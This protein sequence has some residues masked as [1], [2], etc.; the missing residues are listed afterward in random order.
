MVSV[1]QCRRMIR[2]KPSALFRSF[3]REVVPQS[4]KTAWL[5]RW[6]W[7]W[8][9]F[10]SAIV[11]GGLFDVAANIFQSV[12]GTGSLLLTPQIIQTI[13]GW[14]RTFSSNPAANT[15]AAINIAVTVIVALGLFII[16]C[17][18]QGV[19]VYGHGGR[20]VGKDSL[21]KVAVRAG[22]KHLGQVMVLT[23]ITGFFA[24][25]V[26]FA[27]LVPFVLSQRTPS[28]ILTLVSI[29]GAIVYL[30]L[31][32]LLI[33]THI[34]ALN[35]IVHQGARIAE[36]FL[37]AW[38]MARREW[39]H[40]VELGFVLWLINSLAISAAVLAFAV[41]GVPVFLIMVAAALL[42]NPA[43][44]YA[45]YFFGGLLFIATMFVTAAITVS[46]Q[47]GVWHHLYLR[48]GEGGLSPKIHRLVRWFM[49][50]A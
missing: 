3:Y 20:A 48:L 8:A 5:E 41:M 2:K 1:I 49:G 35:A 19:L 6:M 42:N 18:A 24:W 33:A 43:V 39:L 28:V 9:I 13:S 47:Y 46:F 7:P 21:A 30:A 17:I 50:K 37:R 10:A 29:A 23:I 34:F 45:A 11:S 31:T 15:F 26:R 12:R 22:N 36:A 32:V 16:T 4:F 40:L 14:T 25:L 44:L 27:L 38:D